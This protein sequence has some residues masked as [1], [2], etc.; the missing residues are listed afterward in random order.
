MIKVALTLLAGAG[1]AAY[2][3]PLPQCDLVGTTALRGLR[4]SPY[5]LPQDGYYRKVRSLAARPGPVVAKGEPLLAADVDVV[6][7]TVMP[8]ASKAF[9]YSANL[10]AIGFRFD[11]A[12]PQPSVYRFRSRGAETYHVLMFANDAVFVREDGRPCDRVVRFSH[13]SSAIVAYTYATDPEDVRFL[14]EE[15]EQSIGSASLRIVYMGTAAGALHL[16]EV[17]ARD[18]HILRSRPHQFDQFAR[19]VKIAGF[20]LRVGSAAP[21]SGE[22]VVETQDELPVALDE[23]RELINSFSR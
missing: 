14:V 6:R 21:E 9:R 7:R 4:S 1:T 11:P 3:E 8:R 18:G 22:F 23:A 19:T 10:L 13:D 2:A 5:L 17:W 12:R 15:Q 20:Q 16:Q